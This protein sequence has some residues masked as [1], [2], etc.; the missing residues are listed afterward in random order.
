MAE[1]VKDRVRGNLAVLLDR[2]A[3]RG[4]N[5]VG[6]RSDQT[7]RAYYYGQDYRQHHRVLRDVLSVVIHIL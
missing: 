5:V 7:D 1:L 2:A 6:I 3:D 4:K